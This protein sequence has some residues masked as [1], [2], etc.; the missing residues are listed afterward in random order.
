MN[1]MDIYL[2][3]TVLLC[4][5]RLEGH[6]SSVPLPLLA[7]PLQQCRDDK[8]AVLRPLRGS[9]VLFYVLLQWCVSCVL[10]HTMPIALPKFHSR[11][12]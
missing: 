6:L 11:S 10:V 5:S 12:P 1:I 7:E 3:L 4:F 8:L 9:D 2:H